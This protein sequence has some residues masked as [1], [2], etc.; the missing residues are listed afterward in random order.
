MGASTVVR[1]A[2]V[3][4]LFIVRSARG[5]ESCG[6]RKLSAESL[7]AHGYKA[8]YGAWPWH[9]AMFHRFRLGWTSYVC[10]ATIMTE[11]FVLTA[12]HCTY[13]GLQMLPAN[14]VFIK[15]GF[16]NLDSPEDHVRQ[17]EV[18]KII[19]HDEYEKD[20]FENDIALLKLSSIIAFTSYIQPVCLWQGDSQLNKIT[21]KIGYVVGWGLDEAY[22][23]PEH[24]SESTMPIVSSKT[25]WESDRLHYAKYYFES[26]TFCA[27]R[28]NSTHVSHG[29]SGGG[30]SVWIIEP[31]SDNIYDYDDDFDYV[32]NIKGLDTS[33]RILVRNVFV[34]PDYDSTKN[35]NDIALVE[36]G[37]PTTAIPICL[38]TLD[39]FDSPEATQ[40]HVM[41]KYNIPDA[42]YNTQ[43]F[44]E[45]AQ[46]VDLEVCQEKFNMY[47]IEVNLTKGQTSGKQS[48][49][50][51]SSI[52][53]SP[54]VVS[55]FC[56]KEIYYTPQNRARQTNKRKSTSTDDE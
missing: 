2:L 32:S 38:P 5:T 56:Y 25:C 24:L 52:S 4:S 47:Q 3:L 26:K 9:G 42:Y 21:S 37:R 12:A 46:M 43:H 53:Q 27:G 51:S 45:V 34:Q 31:S 22:N 35:G 1:V 54:S 6:E 17:F 33:T 41:H 20:T 36:L 50:K 28:L 8:R 44:R 16:S 55:Y 14:R 29:D 48:R 18:D 7:I 30:L 11:Q 49:F 39:P 23:L 19:R 40:F 15:V 10:G 13:E